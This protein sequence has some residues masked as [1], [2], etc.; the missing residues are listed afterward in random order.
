[1]KHGDGYIMIWGSFGGEKVRHLMDVKGILIKW[2]YHS[3][4]YLHLIPSGSVNI[5]N[6]FIL[7]QGKDAKPTSK[8]CQN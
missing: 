3:V 2:G 6:E 5:G 1:M 4:L 7:Q 8:L